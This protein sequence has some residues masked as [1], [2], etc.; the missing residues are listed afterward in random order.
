MDGQMDGVVDE[1]IRPQSPDRNGGQ[2]WLESEWGCG[3]MDVD[4]DVIGGSLDRWQT[5]DGL[6]A[7]TDGREG[8]QMGGQTCVR[9]DV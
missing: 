6:Q 9:T 2:I 1:W 8:W 4:A 7:Q 3:Q 5:R